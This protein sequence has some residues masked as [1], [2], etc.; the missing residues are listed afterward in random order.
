[1]YTD[2][3]FHNYTMTSYLFYDVMCERFIVVTQSFI[4]SIKYNT[5]IKQYNTT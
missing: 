3:I 1:M 2:H 4:E 5:P